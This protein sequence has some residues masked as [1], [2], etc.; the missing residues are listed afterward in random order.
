MF[1]LKNQKQLTISDPS[2]PM[3]SPSETDLFLP[4]AEDIPFLS[5]SLPAVDEFILEDKTKI[6][7]LNIRLS[8][9][10]N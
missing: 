7:F 10:L 1:P 5:D 9:N 8:L 4:E 3:Q 6:L 2:F